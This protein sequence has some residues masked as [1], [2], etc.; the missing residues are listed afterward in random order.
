M[1]VDKCMWNILIIWLRSDFSF[2]KI[3]NVKQLLLPL[4][5]GS[6]GYDSAISILKLLQLVV[7]FSDCFIIFLRQLN[8]FTKDFTT[9]QLS[10]TYFGQYINRFFPL[11]KGFWQVRY[12]AEQHKIQVKLVD[13]K[14]FSFFNGQI[15]LKYSSSFLI[16]CK[17]FE[18]FCAKITFSTSNNNNVRH[19]RA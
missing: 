16:T 5:T 4:K 11:F 7:S 12:P 3:E 19:R 2:S 8:T 14:W 13:F 10:R 1:Q 9:Q 17:T 6:I 18:K 15:F